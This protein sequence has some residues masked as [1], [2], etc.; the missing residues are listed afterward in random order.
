M[1]I[2]TTTTQEDDNSS[3]A[4]ESSTDSILN[5]VPFSQRT[6]EKSGGEDDNAVEEV[7]VVGNENKNSIA[8][9]SEDQA[10]DKKRKYD[11]T[12]TTNNNNNAYPIPNGYEY[13][14]VDADGTV[15]SDIYD[16][17]PFPTD[18][19]KFAIEKSNAQKAFT[20]TFHNRKVGKLYWRIQPP[21]NG[22]G[23]PRT[24]YPVRLA[25]HDETLGLN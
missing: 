24:Y 10:N 20:A 19:T 14:G 9:Q 12:T 21:K 15:N 8:C 23:G 18:D 13:P 11:D 17:P 1:D 3:V 2:L 25:Q 7:V 4:S 16:G 6:P 22:R 5:M